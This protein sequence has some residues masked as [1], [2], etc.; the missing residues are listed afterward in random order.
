MLYSAMLCSAMPNYAMLCSVAMLGPA[1]LRPAILLHA[2][3]CHVPLIWTV[4]CTVIQLLP[5][6]SSYFAVSYVAVQGG[7]TVQPNLCC[8]T[9]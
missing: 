9:Y 8:W 7:I 2:M 1:M 6:L 3:L 4:D 5:C